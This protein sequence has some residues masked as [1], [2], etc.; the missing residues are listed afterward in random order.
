VGQTL[1]QAGPIP[2]QQQRTAV[3]RLGSGGVV[4]EDD[5]LEATGHGTI[6]P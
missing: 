4:I 5:D 6:V 1:E 3:H 2:L